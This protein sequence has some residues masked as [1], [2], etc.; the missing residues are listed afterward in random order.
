[1]DGLKTGDL[2][3]IL[4]LY[5]PWQIASVKLDEVAKTLVVQVLNKEYQKLPTQQT[6]NKAPNL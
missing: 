3:R 5:R 6:A 4:G 2:A 1:M